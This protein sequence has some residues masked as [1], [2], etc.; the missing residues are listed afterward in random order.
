MKRKRRFDIQLTFVGLD[1]LLLGRTE[2][3]RGD[4]I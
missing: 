1:H 3:I 4:K 2:M